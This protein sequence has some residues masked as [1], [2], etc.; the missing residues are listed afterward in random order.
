[1]QRA[2]HL[3]Q[4]AP[5]HAFFGG[6]GALFLVQRA[7]LLRQLV[8][9]LFQ[10]HRGNEALAGQAL[11][12]RV[13]LLGLAEREFEV[14]PAALVVG[15]HGFLGHA[16]VGRVED[17]LRVFGLARQQFQVALRV[18]QAEQQVAL[19]DG[20]AVLREHLF[21]AAGFDRV[22]DDRIERLGGGA[23]DDV[24]AEHALFDAGHAHV[25][26]GYLQS[27]RDELPAGPGQAGRDGGGGADA[28]QQLAAALGD[29][30]VHGGAGD[31]GR[32][33]T[34]HVMRLVEG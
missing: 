4:R 25:A 27:V 7:L 24:V 1:V 14:G 10:R 2:V 34:V 17:L 9:R 23:H 19:P 20:L 28:R 30:G 16:Q 15:A 13:L 12:A 5:A 21:H 8:G 29:D 11:V 22:E 6:D 18:R 33:N 31:G 3:V 26:A 32:R